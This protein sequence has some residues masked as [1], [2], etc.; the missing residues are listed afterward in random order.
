M[1]WADVDP[2]KNQN[3]H[4]R[5]ISC[6]LTLVTTKSRAIPRD[7]QSCQVL[8]PLRGAQADEEGD[9]VRGAQ[10]VDEQGVSADS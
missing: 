6:V 5:V 9:K 4:S 10:S 2:N 1:R 8:E 7:A 3:P